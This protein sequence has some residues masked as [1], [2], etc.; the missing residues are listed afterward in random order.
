MNRNLVEEFGPVRIL[1]IDSGRQMRGGQWQVL[2][3]MEGLA[4]AGCETL[5]LA[6]DGAPLAA[7][8]CRRGLAAE[9]L[10]LRNLQR[11]LR[12]AEL[13]H[14]HDARSHTLVALF[15]H[16]SLVVSR[17]VAFPL[18]RGPL[19]RW[20]YGR[21]RRYL[22]VSEHVKQVLAA[23]GVPP[24]RITVVHDGVPLLPT[25]TR[26]GGIVAPAFSDPL[27]AGAL[28]ER[29]ARTGGFQIRRSADL[30]R[31]LREAAVLVYL[32]QCE[33]LGS[34]VLLAMAAA[35]PVIASRVGGLT[36]IVQDGETGLLVD[37]TPES[38]V[39]AIRRLRD[40]ASLAERLAAAGRR[41]IEQRFSLE[42][43]K[44]NTL[45]VYREV[46]SC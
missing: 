25:S 20:K 39:E 5:L 2:Y 40:D 18:R 37:N 35:V 4:R 10:T 7:A 41:Q 33:G 43:L 27:K 31:D 26:S 9:A 34:G 44:E 45:R 42:A 21:V 36:E 1:H 14:A 30:E 15:G 24:N 32:S 6:P 28:L 23:G 13:V 22:A 29:A 46:L 19:S 17:R 3:L 11:H 12:R 38:V 16:P 8:A